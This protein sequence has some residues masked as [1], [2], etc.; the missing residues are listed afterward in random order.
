MAKRTKQQK[1]EQY[2][3]VSIKAGDSPLM[4]LVFLADGTCW[5]V[6]QPTT[7]SDTFVNLWRLKQAG[8]DETIQVPKSQEV[9]IQKLYL[10]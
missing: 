5:R 8:G 3:R 2:E 4:S 7:K 1:L 10:E 6:Q 9:K